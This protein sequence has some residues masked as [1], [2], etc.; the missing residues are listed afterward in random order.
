M[1]LARGNGRKP[2]RDPGRATESKAD[3]T[4]L[5]ST[6][7]VSEA[8]AKDVGRG[9]AR[10]DPKDMAELGVD[11]GDVVEVV[12]KQT[13]VARVMPAHAELRGKRTIQIDGISRANAGASLGEQVVVRR[14]EAKNARTIV[15]APTDA[16]TRSARG[17]EGRYLTRLLDG[18]P[19]VPGDRVRVNPFGTQVRN[20]VVAKAAPEGPVVVVP[21]TTITCEGAAQRREAITYEDVGGLHKE[22]RRVREIIELPLK[23]PEVF[24]HLG[25]EAPKGVLLYGPPGTGKTLIARA[26]AHESGVHFTHINGPEIIDKFY[27]AS[28]AQLRKVFE[29]A[30]RNAPAIIFID[31]IDAIAPKREEMGGERQVE[32]RVVAQLLALMDGLETRGQVVIIAATNIPNSLDPALRRPGRFDREIEIGIPDKGGRRE[33]LEIH[34][35]GMPLAE[36]VELERLAAITHGFVGADL[37]SLCR[38]AAMNALRRLMPDIDF[39]KTEIPYDKLS[40]L[41]VEWSDFENALAEVE[42]SA[43]RE[44]ATEISNVR[45]EDVG[46]AEEIKELLTEVVLWQLKYDVLFRRAGVRA[47]KGV[48]LCGAPG[49]GKTL[50][51]KA[52]AGET[53]ANFIA[54]KGP[55][56]LSRWVGE[57]ERGVR[58]IFRKARQAAPCIIFFDEIDALAPRRGGGDSQVTER[59]VAQLLTELD[60]IED[61]KGVVVLAA[62]NRVDRLD[63]A[64]L[65]PGRLEF[66]IE[67]PT[68]DA[69]ARRAILQ[70]HTRRMPLDR[71]VNLDAVVNGTEG[72]VGAD[73][74]GICRQAALFAIREIVAPA[75][76]SGVKEEASGEPTEARLRQLMVSKRHFDKALAE[77]K[78]SRSQP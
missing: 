35:R 41:K 71:N 36:D 46:G 28:E 70:V 50:L 73:L 33:A 60:G 21:G 15:L 63:P 3:S 43:L 56:L 4:P 23:Y 42:P 31:E 72:L 25:I 69:A 30:E 24:S 2:D 62:T 78:L 59:V 48:L 45:W 29:Q 53:E 10:L 76:A 75:S 14:S 58:E 55:Q 67:L 39:K 26:V 51:A 57:S 19:L 6:Y 9:L 5:N 37:A 66:H 52:L 47:P 68:P 22:L 17:L 16:P 40:A 44:V 11:I 8:L 1:T 65:R 64:L 61:L 7:R 54:V 49:T 77:R 74:E 27:G 38:E 18:I 20:F 34:S 12:A 13:T 32:R